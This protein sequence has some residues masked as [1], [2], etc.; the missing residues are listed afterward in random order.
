M[1][2]KVRVAFP[3]LDAHT[4][5]MADVAG[6]TLSITY[7]MQ[8]MP[9][10]PENTDIFN[11]PPMF[12]LMKPQLRVDNLVVAEGNSV[13][14]GTYHN[15]EVSLL[16]P[17]VD[18]W[19]IYNKGL[20]A[21]SSANICLTTQETSAKFMQE[22]VDALKSVMDISSLTPEDTMTVEMVNE[23]LRL[24]GLMYFTLMDYITNIVSNQ[25]GII[26]VNHVSLAFI[27]DEIIPIGFFGLVFLIKKGGAHI[28]IVRTAN[29]PVSATGNAEDR[30]KWMQIQGGFGT[31]MEHT[32]L[33][34]MYDIEAVST[35]KIF[36]EANKAG[37]P[38]R[39]IKP[40]TLEDD[41]AQIS[42]HSVVKDHIRAFLM[43]ETREFEALIP[44]RGIT[45]GS[46][47]G[48]GWI[49]MEPSTGCAGYM[50]CGGLHN[51]NM[52]LNGGS[53]IEK[54]NNAISELAQLLAMAHG[55]AEA[56][57]VGTISLALAHFVAAMILLAEATII[58]SLF[59]IW[60]AAI[61]ACLAIV[62][63]AILIQMLKNAMHHARYI[64]PSSK[65]KP[66]IAF[67]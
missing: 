15:L 8:Q 33:E 46:W 22:K 3:D 12:T 66:V 54:L 52:I 10:L 4:F 35:G 47:S 9:W 51:S 56:F 64:I 32:M 60:F 28:D 49:I 13:Y 7:K 17:G 58:T 63:L 42:A 11:A 6:K 37:I 65:G 16:R 57:I 38:I 50:I 1:R 31:N 45:L 67:A 27:V 30:V 53:L 48:Q 39:V 61:G 24:D 21:G 23:S 26:N 59:G 36:S 62:S 18:T 34:T 43:H 25:M 40:E 5:L 41:L 2:F 19:E 29:N 20:I 44:Q 55:V 14:L